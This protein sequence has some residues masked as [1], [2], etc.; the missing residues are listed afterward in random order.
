MKPMMVMM[1]MIAMML[2]VMMV[3]PVVM[4][5]VVMVLVRKELEGKDVGIDL[6][7]LHRSS[8]LPQLWRG[9]KP[10]GETSKLSRPLQLL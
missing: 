9:E 2:V 1:V 10:E 3:M 5:L 7:R 6:Q 8:T 4:V